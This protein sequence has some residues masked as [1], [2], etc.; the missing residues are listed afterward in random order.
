MSSIQAWLEDTVQFGH[1]LIQKKELW[2]GRLHG[3]L[4]P[5]VIAEI[6]FL[7]QKLNKWKVLKP[8]TWRAQTLR[9]EPVFEAIDI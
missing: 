6:K 1:Y 4:S 7:R 5:Q 2:C 3:S 9:P 8:Q